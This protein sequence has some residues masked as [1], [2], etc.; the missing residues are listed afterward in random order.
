MNQAANGNGNGNGR[1]AT[2][3]ARAHNSGNVDV[4][5][6]NMPYASLPRPSIALSLLKQILED[7]GI[8]AT[9]L[10]PNLWFAEQ[11]GIRRYHLCSHQCPT[12]FL[13]GEWTFA[14]AA[15]HDTPHDEEYLRHVTESNFRVFSYDKVEDRNRLLE[16]LRWNREAATRF[17]DEAAQRVLAS[18]ARIVGCTSTFEQH[19]ASLALLRRIRELDP[20]VITMMGGAN[21][22]TVMG[23]TTHD[24]FPWVDYVVSG[25]AD[26]LIVDLCKRI[27]EQGRDI[28]TAELPSGVLGPAHRKPRQLTVL[29][30]KNTVER[31]L[32]RELDDLPIPDF[33]DYFA[34]LKDSSVGYTISPGLPLETSR[35]CWWGAI[36]HCTFCGLNG[37]SMAFR[38][39]SPE[40]VLGEVQTLEQRYGISNFETV[41]NILDMAYFKT[42]LPRLA[43]DGGHRKLF[44]EVKANLSRKQVELLKRSGV[45][46]IQPGIE[47]LHSGVLRLMDKGVQGWQNVQLLKWAREFGL[48]MSWAV[49]WGFPGEE[50]DW[51]TQMAEWLPQLEHLQAPSGLIRLRY[52]R[53]SVYHNRAQE[54]ELKLLP[55]SAMSFVYPLAPEKLADLAYFFLSEGSPDAFHKAG[56]Y[57]EFI[58]TRPGL[59]QVLKG[60]KRWRKEFWRGLTPILALQDDGEVLEIL[61]SRSCAEEFRTTFTGLARAVCLACDQAPLADRLQGILKKNYNLD[62]SLEEIEAVTEHLLRRKLLMAIDGRLIT[63]AVAGTLPE[64]PSRKDFPGGFVNDNW[65]SES[66]A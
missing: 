63:L 55:I 65:L 52:D 41:D 29:N 5:L 14:A 42:V 40:R 16:D 61:D 3:Q 60:V 19:V 33:H 17:I 37:S 21:C 12:E 46:W 2:P 28:S 50:D 39:K 20:S 13:A 9:V 4:C 6:V 23:G 64:L 30:G 45:T 53:F 35:G 27:L 10:Y 43:S 48:R 54:M 36:H 22:E 51:Y 38:S 25:E 58:H 1:Q 31:A 59:A 7:G 18:G 47:S 57:G 62:A 49:L 44:Y 66:Q 24:S 8:R 15:F 32:F 56:G 26:G 34:Q 11:V